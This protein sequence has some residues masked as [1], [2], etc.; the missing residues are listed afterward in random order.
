MTTFLLIRHGTNDLV[1]R[2]IAGWMPGVHLNEEGRTQAERL[3][4]RLRETRIAAIYS[5]PLDRAC[6]TA[7]PIARQKG[8]PVHICQG[9]GEIQFGDWTG[10]SLEDLA[11]VPGWQQFNSF[12]SGTRVP[13][14]ELMLEV[15]ARAVAEL[16]RVRERHPKGVVVVVSHGDVIKA[17]VA[18]YAGIPLDLFQRVDISPA[19]V[20]ILTVDESGPRILRINDTGQLPEL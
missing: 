5:S 1:D 19:S 14:G 16:E 3:A 15:Q 12:R 13:G 4:V 6:E 8:L 2:A 17:A 10:R 20:S 7:E 18:H 9:V 11:G